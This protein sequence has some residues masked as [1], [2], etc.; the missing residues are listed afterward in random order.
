M[1]GFGIGLIARADNGGLGT[2]SWEFWR[3][4]RPE[5]T[6]IV[7]RD[8][9][10]RGECHWERYTGGAGEVRITKMYPTTKDASWVTSG[11]KTV[12]AAETAYSTKM[13]DWS[14]RNGSKV[15]I[16][17]N[18]ELFDYERAD[19]LL[20]ATNW[21]TDVFP[22]FE[23]LPV[24]VNR[25]ALPPREVKR[26]RTFY[27]VNS[28]A[29]ED[30]NGTELVLSACRYMKNQARLLIRGGEPRTMQVGRV[31]VTWPGG[32]TGPYH[33][34]W[35]DDVDALV[36]PRRYGGLCLPAQEA[37]SLGLPVIMLDTDPYAYLI[38]PMLLVQGFV[39]KRVHM[40][41]G[42]FDVHAC[43]PQLLAAR[44]DRL[45]D[46]PSIAAEASVRSDAWAEMHSWPTLL[47][48]YDRILR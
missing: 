11:V 5:R 47:P 48:Y 44:M 42:Q 33:D 29:M 40:K 39:K 32:F 14:R 2:Q 41:G 25:E 30:R 1:S 6:L 36:L 15:C 43:R 31:E 8:H 19:R 34:H 27:H 46:E 16:Q 24:P 20:P 10:T 38:H 3:H 45:Y 23:V 18:P 4:M 9:R 17:A 7:L 35:P 13:W 12:F 26:V 21:R 37:A 22:E 28:V